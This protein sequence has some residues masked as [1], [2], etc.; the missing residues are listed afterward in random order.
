MQL[1]SSF[2]SRV[3]QP[4]NSSPLAEINIPDDAAFIGTYKY[5]SSLGDVFYGEKINESVE[6]KKKINGIKQNYGFV[7]EFYDEHEEMNKYF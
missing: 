3:T 2:T 4:V 6:L 7:K 1:I 5:A